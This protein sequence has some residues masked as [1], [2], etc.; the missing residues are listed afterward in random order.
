MSAHVICAELLGQNHATLLFKLAGIAARR[1]IGLL[2]QFVPAADV[3]G[4]DP[5]KGRLAADKDEMR[6]KHRGAIVATVLT[7]M[8]APK[9]NVRFNIGKGEKRSIGQG[10]RQSHEKQIST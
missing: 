7:I 8:C 3:N 4:S 10:H 5:L 2:L 1:P 9:R 6:T